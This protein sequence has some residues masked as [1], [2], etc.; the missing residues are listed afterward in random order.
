[1][2]VLADAMYPLKFCLPYD[3]SKSVWFQYVA[4]DEAC[5]FPSPRFPLPSS[6]FPR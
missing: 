5:T 4:T 1:M 2:T 6:T 3:P